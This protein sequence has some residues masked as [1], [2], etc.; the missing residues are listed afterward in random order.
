MAVFFRRS[1]EDPL[2]RLPHQLGC[3]FL[4]QLQSVR[5]KTDGSG[6]GRGRGKKNVTQFRFRRCRVVDGE[7]G[8]GLEVPEVLVHVHDDVPESLHLLPDRGALCV[9]GHD[10]VACPHD[11][12]VPD[13]RQ[14]NADAGSLQGP[15]GA[16]AVQNPH[17]A[18]GGVRRVLVHLP[19]GEELHGSE[20]VVLAVGSVQGLVQVVST[21]PA[22]SSDGQPRLGRVQAL[23]LNVERVPLV[24]RRQEDDFQRNGVRHA[25]GHGLTHPALSPLPLLAHLH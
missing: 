19:A 9:H 16:V 10:G 6:V 23:V 21:V 24:E 4:R 18:A 5:V 14:Q 12:H 20:V 2:L 13:L 3:L 8:L 11:A 15:D 17:A 25:L 7:P 22:V 1:H